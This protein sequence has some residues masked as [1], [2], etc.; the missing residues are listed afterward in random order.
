MHVPSAGGHMIM[1]TIPDRFGERSCP[2]VLARRRNPSRINRHNMGRRRGRKGPGIDPFML[3]Y[4]GAFHHGWAVN[5]E[6]VKTTGEQRVLN[7]FTTGVRQSS[8]LSRPRVMAR[9]IVLVAGYIVAKIV[10]RCCGRG[11]VIRLGLRPAR[12]A[13]G[14][15]ESDEARGTSP[16]ASR[17]SS[18]QMVFLV[19]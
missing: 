9:T 7:S 5:L 12:R 8:S 17:T 2:I 18:G 11:S 1:G 14:L 6:T 15:V 16:A 10:A 4:E 13:R 19:F 3:N